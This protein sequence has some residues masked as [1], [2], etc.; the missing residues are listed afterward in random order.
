MRKC[1][2]KKHILFKINFSTLLPPHHN[3]CVDMSTL[4]V[5]RQAVAIKL[6]LFI[7][8][9]CLKCKNGPLI[10]ENPC[11]FCFCFFNLSFIRIKENKHIT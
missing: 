2:W 9:T 5:L 7:M 11:N 4:C 3:G 6:Q 1:H 8:P 10:L